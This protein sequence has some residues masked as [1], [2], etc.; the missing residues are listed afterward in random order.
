MSTEYLGEVNVRFPP[1]CSMVADHGRAARGIHPIDPVIAGGQIKDEVFDVISRRRP[2]SVPT[3]HHNAVV[4]V[5]SVLPARLAD[6]PAQGSRRHAAHNELPI[7]FHLNEIEAIDEILQFLEPGEEAEIVRRV[8]RGILGR[9]QA[10]QLVET[11]ATP[12]E[13]LPGLDP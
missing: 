8:S 10:I 9:E 6:S 13:E 12:D 3:A 5:E 11:C 7:L 2:V 4:Q 1:V